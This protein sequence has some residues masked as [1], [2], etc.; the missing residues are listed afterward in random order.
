MT[1]RFGLWAHRLSRRSERSDPIDFHVFTRRQSCSANHG[2]LCLIVRAIRP[3]ISRLV[4]F[5][6]RSA[7]IFYIVSCELR[8]ANC[9]QSFARTA[10][11]CT[12]VLE[13]LY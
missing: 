6:L 13:F 8:V 2:K 1:N 9:R 10:N 5:E 12:F 4:I 7:I 3:G 11:C